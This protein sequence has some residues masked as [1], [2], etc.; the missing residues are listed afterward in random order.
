MFLC[1]PK[2]FYLDFG[3]G[4]FGVAF[5]AVIYVFIV[6]PI[7]SLISWYFCRKGRLRVDISKRMFREFWFA[8][9]VGF[10][11]F[12]GPFFILAF[13][14]PLYF[15]FHFLSMI[16]L[17]NV[18]ESFERKFL[19]IYYGITTFLIIGLAIMNKIKYWE[20]LNQMFHYYTTEGLKW[21]GLYFFIF[22]FLF[23]LAFLNIKISFKKK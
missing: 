20:D 12:G 23:V 5:S 1:D 8:F 2:S 3:V 17:K 9:I 7:F 4:W 16:L 11:S 19:L 22:I 6:N 13:M 21:F 14:Y 15:T 18:L 10:F